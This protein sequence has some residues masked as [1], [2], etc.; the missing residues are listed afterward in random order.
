[1]SVTVDVNV[2]LHASDSESRRHAVALRVLRELTQASELTYLFWPVALG[3]LRISTHPAVLAAPL[4]PRE[5]IGNI[6]ALLARPNVRA[7]GEGGEFWQHFTQVAA[8]TPLRG[9]LVPDGQ[10]VALMREHGV[11][12]VISHD[13]DLRKF[14]GIRVRDPFA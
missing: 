14:S 3:Y 2:L 1:M 8:E 11:R 9:N 4:N 12:T 10:L 5:A 13:R 7:V 6:E